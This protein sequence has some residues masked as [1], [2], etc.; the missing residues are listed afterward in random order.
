MKCE[1]A[2]KVEDCEGC[3]HA[4]EHETLTINS[5]GLRCDHEGYCIS[6]GRT[7]RCAES[8]VCRCSVNDTSAG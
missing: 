7:V 3:S 4:E 1:Y 2:G 6:A 8:G 5:L